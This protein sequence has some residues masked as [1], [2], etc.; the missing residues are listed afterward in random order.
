MTTLPV[1]LE[2]L[3]IREQIREL[4]ANE[5]PVFLKFSYTPVLQPILGIKSNGNII[6]RQSLRI[7]RTRIDDTSITDNWKLYPED[8]K[9]VAK[10]LGS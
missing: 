2:D 4:L 3:S 8:G 1:Y 10:W 7:G 6:Y 5:E 9:Y